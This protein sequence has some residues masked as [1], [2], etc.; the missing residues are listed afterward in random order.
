MGV[1]WC[2]FNLWRTSGDIINVWDRVMENLLSTTQF[3]VN[4]AGP[5]AP[6]VG[7]PLEPPT[8]FP[9]ASP[10][11]PDDGLPVSRPGCWAYPD[12]LEVGR[13]ATADESASHMAAWAIVS[14]PLVL[15]FDLRNSTRLAAAWPLISNRRMMEVSRTW[16]ADRLGPSGLLLR[17]WRDT[18]LPALTVGCG[19]S[20]PCQDRNA[21]CAQWAAAGQC[22]K[23]PGYMLA[24][25]PASC[26]VSTNQS[27]WRLLDDGRVVT[28]RGDCLD[29]A[30]QLPGPGSGLN[31]LRTRPCGE[32]P[33][34]R[35]SWT[36][37]NGTGTL[38]SLWPRA[39]GPCIGA[40]SHWLWPQPMVSLMDCGGQHSQLTLGEG[41]VLK[42]GNGLGC[43]GDSEI[44]TGPPSTLW[45]KP[46]SGGRTAVL[47]INAAAIAHD[48]TV[49]YAEVLAEDPGAGGLQQTATDVWTGAKL[50]ANSTSITLTVAPH[51]NAFLVLEPA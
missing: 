13:T 19:P 25:C 24:V 49:D 8:Y 44:L 42:V 47:A 2:P 1:G 11:G 5:G 31:W 38:R 6:P 20:C 27:G 18:T 4:S 7:R 40:V 32:Q 45:R 22:S 48:I 37:T 29:A 3:L 23:N 34:Q 36:P 12:M 30:G 26:P 9:P 35:W 46:L 21:R 15:G 14:A 10:P 50:N 17:S 51:G 16:E 33:S 41:G 28:P 43:I 39:A